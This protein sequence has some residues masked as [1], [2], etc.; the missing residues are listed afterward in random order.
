MTEKSK[1]RKLF[2]ITDKERFAERQSTCQLLP[3]EDGASQQFRALSDVE[4][5]DFARLLYSSNKNGIF[6]GDA[7]LLA[8][9]WQLPR[10]VASIA[11]LM[12]LGFVLEADDALV[13]KSLINYRRWREAKNTTE[14]NRVG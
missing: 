13:V 1:S 9:I 7:E 8:E 3:Y 11:K 14:R 12:R 10:M 2:S 4:I 5:A 6:I